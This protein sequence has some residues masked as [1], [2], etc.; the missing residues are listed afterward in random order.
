MTIIEQIKGGVNVWVS[1]DEYSGNQE[2]SLLDLMYGDVKQEDLAKAGIESLEMVQ[3]PD[4]EMMW[5]A[6]IKT[7]TVV[8]LKGDNQLYGAFWKKMIGSHGD[9]DT[10]NAHFQKV[11]AVNQITTIYKEVE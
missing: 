1:V 3:M 9:N 10:D 8:K 2:F 6:Q 7:C 4:K 11:E 5:S